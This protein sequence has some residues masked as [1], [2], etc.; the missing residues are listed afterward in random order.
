MTRKELIADDITEI[1]ERYLKESTK[2][3]LQDN[4]NLISEFKRFYETTLRREK[5]VLDRLS[6]LDKAI[7]KGIEQTNQ[8]I[9]RAK[10]QKE[11]Q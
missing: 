3:V 6:V 9:E 4:P 5:I 2:E 10:N 11:E 1:I 7:K 8:M